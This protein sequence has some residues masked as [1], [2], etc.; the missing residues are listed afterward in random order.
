MSSAA[1]GNQERDGAATRARPTCMKTNRSGNPDPALAG[2]TVGSRAGSRLRGGLTA[3]KG[4]LPLSGT[5]G[6]FLL[7]VGAG[8][9][10]DPWGYS[11]YLAIKV[12]SAAAGLLLMLGFL[13]RE[14]VLVV[15]GGPW[16]VAGSVLLGL[17][18][19]STA[20]SEAVWRSLLGSPIRFEGLL[21]WMSFATALL[22]GL[23]L[24]HRLRDVASGPFIRLAV[25]A[26]LIVGTVGVLEAVGVEI[27]P[28]TVPF[29]GRVRSTFGNPATLAGF[30]V[31]VGPVAAVAV[32]RGDRWR[33]AGWVSCLLVIYNLAV[34]QTR[35]ALAAAALWCVVAGLARLRGRRR[36]IVA[37]AVLALILGS[38]FS[39]RWQQ[40]GEDLDRRAAVW[41]VA[42]S[43]IADDPLLG[44][45]P[46]MFIAGY[47]RHVADETVREFGRY[48][49]VDRAHNIVLDFAAAYG[50]PAGVLFASIL[51]AVA[52]LAT[53]AVRRGDWFLVAVASGVGI[54]MLQQQAFFAHPT[55]DIL[56]WLMVGVLAADSGIRLLTAPRSV[57]IATLGI[58]AVLL[59]NAVS[60]IHNDRLYIQ[61]VQPTPA[62][63]AY[64][65]LDR[66][67]S[68]RPFDD[69]TYLLMGAVLSDVGDAPL[70]ARGVE[71]IERGA[72][73]NPGNELVSFALSDVRLQ[74][75]RL[76]AQPSYAS[77]AA[78]DL[79]TLIGEQPANGDAYLKRG[80]AFYY[81]GDIE[82]AR[83]DWH[84]AAF[85]MPERPEPLQNLEVINATVQT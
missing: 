41:G 35:S 45:G 22:V 64:E 46:E 18:V 27:D 25:L 16:A 33:W 69:L 62:Y 56:W 73:L 85:L 26:V 77:E 5:L 32:G 15:P 76:T 78:H 29:M 7:L 52:V 42:V 21:A 3:R 17:M 74:A 63:E 40:V 23:S 66:A 44:S 60:I 8:A 28:D 37:V 65:Y 54:Y 36:W 1:D 81:L 57:L 72:R 71:A 50:V 31:L 49:V 61:T 70:V 24:W 59:L 10:F 20:T 9:L 19:V 6:L 80:V 58:A 13:Q 55:L 53:R 2:L 79:S 82:A 30:L 83:T 75:Y 47:G 34:A 14:R 12:V 4:R 68:R 51:A 67:A 48:P 84:R 43:V 39:D 11:G 38:A